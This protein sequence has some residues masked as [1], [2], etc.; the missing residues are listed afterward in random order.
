M[1]I[2]N[3]IHFDFLPALPGCKRGENLQRLRLLLPLLFFVFS[4]LDARANGASAKQEESNIL[5][6]IDHDVKDPQIIIDALPE[7]LKS[8]T[9]V[10]QPAAS[11][12]A[13]VLDLF[14]ELKDQS[15]D[16]F[17]LFSHGAPGSIYLG[18]KALGLNELD[19]SG[20]LNEWKRVIQENGEMLLYGCEI[21]K[22]QSGHDLIT[23]ITSSHIDVAAS[24][25]VTGAKDKGGDW[26]LEYFTANNHSVVAFDSNIAESYQH[27]LQT[28]FTFENGTN[29]A[30]A[31]SFTQ[32]IGANTIKVEEPNGGTVRYQLI[33]F[34]ISSPGMW[35]G[36]DGNTGTQSIRITLNNGSTFQFSQLDWVGV[37]G[38]NITVTGRLNG[39]PV[40]S[41]SFNA[42][43]F[44]G[45][46][47]TTG[48][49]GP[50]N[51]VIDELIIT[52][53]DTYVSVGLDNVVLTPA[54]SSSPPSV[55][56]S[57]ATAVIATGA[58]LN[59]DVTANG[60]ATVTARGF[61]YSSIDNTPEIGES[62]VTQVPDGSGTG[63]FSESIS[64]LSSN[65]TYYFQAYATNNVGTNYGS[66]DQFT[67]L[68]NPPVFVSGASVS[69]AENTGTGTTI[70]DVNA[71]NGDGG[72][73]DA[74][75]TYSLSGT[76]AGDFNI[77]SS[78]GVLTFAAVPDFENPADNDG[79]NIYNV[80][81]TANDG[82]GNN[83]TA[84]QNISITV[85]DVAES[86][87]KNVYVVTQNTNSFTQDV[88]AGD[89]LMVNTGSGFNDIFAGQTVTNGTKVAVDPTNNRAWIMDNRSSNNDL[90]YQVNL[91][92]GA[93]TTL[94]TS[95]QAG[96]G[97]TTI[98]DIE[99]DAQ[100]DRLYFIEYQPFVSPVNNAF[101]YYDFNTST[102]NVVKQDFGQTPVTLA[103][104][105]NSNRAWI[106]SN[107]NNEIYRIDLSN[108][109]S[110]TISTGLVNINDLE[111]SESE[112]RLYFIQN[113][114]F[115]NGTDRLAYMDAAG[116]GIM[117]ISTA[118][119]YV[120]S[121]ALDEVNGL[122]YAIDIN[123]DV[124]E[125]NLSNGSSTIFYNGSNL[126]DPEGVAVFSS[127]G[128]GL[129][130]SPPTVSTSAATAVT[131]TGASLNGDVT[132]NGGTT[133]TARGFVYSSIDNTP[134]IGE[135]NVTQ[136][137]DGSGTGVFSES[138]SG[139]S[140]NTTYYVQAYAINSQDTSYGGVETFTTLDANPLGAFINGQGCLECATY[141]VRDSFAINGIWYTK[142]DRTMLDSMVA[143]LPT[144]D[145]TRVCVSGV[146]DMEGLFANEGGFNQDIGAWDVSSVNTMRGMFYR[147]LVFNQDL[148]GW[149]VSGVTTM[150][151]MF[152]D[153]LVFNDNIGPWDVSSVTNMRRMFKFAGQF[154]SDISSWDVSSVT[155]MRSMF[156]L[157]AA[158]DQDLSGWCVDQIPTQ[159][160]NFKVGSGLTA[161]HVPLWGSCSTSSNPALNA[162]GCVECASAPVRSTFTLDGITYTV[163]D[164]AMLDSMVTNGGD[165]TKVCV[166]NVTDF[167][168]LF[169][170]QGSFNQDISTWDVSNGTTTRGMFFRAT[171]FNQDIGNWDVSSVSDVRAMF[172]QAD[173]FNQDIGSWDVS[174]VT[175]MQSMFQGADAF[176]QDIGNWDVSS[177]TRMVRM[178]Q[179]AAA[180]NQDLTGWC[181]SLI[182]SRPGGFSHLGVLTSANEPSWGTCPGTSTKRDLNAASDTDQDNSEVAW[183][184]YG[185]YGETYLRLPTNGLNHTVVIYNVNGQPVDR[186]TTDQEEVQILTDVPHGIYLIHLNGK[187][188]R[189]VK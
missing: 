16:E 66:V 127:S 104:D 153:A 61:V 10:L 5:V 185:K 11:S 62:N 60:G 9:H 94:Y 136:V 49:T 54:A 20:L 111:W 143:N 93:L 72:G 85:T 106:R 161:G 155:N 26:D 171:A 114:A 69:V 117:N 99:Y 173:A 68:N 140:D 139:L 146:S 129:S 1:L 75:I 29:Q 142:V 103:L 131:A 96:G 157:A 47:F 150:E 6:I 130:A 91:T 170:N 148:S 115:G 147:A 112:G 25:D 187:T 168:H 165:F 40:G 166:S 88:T 188:Q 149:D 58:S 42:V 179:R 3:L 53:A 50:I 23:N 34:G 78:T 175:N 27:L 98:G 36:N 45:S 15:V 37:L 128:P 83:N 184:A 178:F 158:F 19:E 151:S 39:N 134:E 118:R 32:T 74:G 73:N 8:N 186:F 46:N 21:A 77:N 133:V 38:D 126:K 164:R 84:T 123:E 41:V 57:A 102:R 4:A 183:Y 7:D 22:G 97:F 169:R 33:N 59:G 2:Q 163:V 154:N 64:G 18:G 105:V 177:A 141:A 181:V 70:L 160:V 182:P 28:T 76:D 101:V 113:S 107:G 65:T 30:T 48:T 189:V 13:Q 92:T 125:I 145:F 119:G 135:S 172:Y 95:G 14:R 162:N 56:T 90:I 116:N 79:N 82:L 12:L 55:S 109:S 132:A 120:Q 24:V 52:S 156:R 43:A 17:H 44:N 86:S 159:P 81:V 121:L 137:P 180:F 67:T 174:S 144:S 110:T 138:I 108:G 122:A 176:N 87:T 167:S 35:I 124:Y 80:T 100:N 63:V 71:N 89:A 152:E 31:N 51:G